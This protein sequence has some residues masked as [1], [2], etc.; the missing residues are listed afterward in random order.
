[1]DRP[2]DL[3]LTSSL[4]AGRFARIF[5]NVVSPPSVLALLGLVVALTTLPFWPGLA[6]AAVH[7]FLISLVPLGVIVY[8]LKTGRV[9]D[10][11]MRNKNERHTPY[12]VGLTCAVLALSVASGFGAPKLLRS[13]IACNII[14]LATLGFINV[15]WLI[16]SHSASIMLATLFV[17][18]VFGVKA[19]IAL[20]P[21]IGLTIFARLVLRRHTVPQLV[22][23]LFAGAAP[24]LILAYFGYLS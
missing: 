14:A 18:F 6:W 1:M 13:L 24:V 17:G 21:L 7:G 19:G 4:A 15:Y 8:L 23:G 3:N 10:L 9:G 12:L 11:H 20:I 16:S 2:Q 22:A 5:S